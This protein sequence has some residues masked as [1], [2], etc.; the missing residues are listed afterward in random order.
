MIFEEYSVFLYADHAPD[1]DNG[2][3][4]RDEI[5]RIVQKDDAGKDVIQ[6]KIGLY[7][8]DADRNVTARFTLTIPELT[9][10]SPNASI[11]HGIVKGDLVVDVDDFQLVDTKVEGNVYF[12]EQAYKD[13]FVMDA[14]SSITGKNEVKSN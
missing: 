11:Q 4:E 5:K 6:R 2:S 14:D 1:D 7:T 13:S 12:T 9:I 3:K 8:Q 10:K